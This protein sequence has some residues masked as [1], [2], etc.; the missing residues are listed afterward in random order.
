MDFLKDLEQKLNE[1]ESQLAEM[2]INIEEPDEDTIWNDAELCFEHA[3][4]LHRHDEL[5]EAEKYFKRS[6]KLGKL[7]AYHEIGEIYRYD[8][9]DI[10]E[11]ISWYNKGI[12]AGDFKSYYYL[13]SAYLSGDMLE[14][15]ECSK[16]WNLF[17]SKVIGRIESEGQETLLGEDSDV[18]ELYYMMIR[19]V[20]D[21]S[22]YYDEDTQEIITGNHN[23]K[24]V[25]GMCHKYLMPRVLRRYGVS[26]SDDILGIM[27]LDED[28]REELITILNLCKN[29]IEYIIDEDN[30]HFI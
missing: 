8:H 26:G 15:D 24:V 2:G 3:D 29:C 18:P 11:A 19:D 14:W 21:M 9:D 27:Q 25:I 6:I 16:A 12:D 17:T 22:W 1:I 10:E 5:D 28:R 7:D 30:Q 4:T 20:V 23:I 13:G